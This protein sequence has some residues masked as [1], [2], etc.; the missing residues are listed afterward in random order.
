[1]EHR[2]APLL[3]HL[4]F[5]PESESAR[6]LARTIHRALNA[7]PQ[8]PGLRIPT[9]FCADDGEGRPPADQG[10]DE[11]R[12]SFVVPLADVEMNIDDDWCG[13]VA[14][15]WEA[16][17]EGPH[18]CF[19]IQLT[20]DAWPLDDRLRTINFVRGF[21]LSETEQRDF[22][23]RRIVIE[24]CRYLHG[25]PTAADDDRLPA[26][27]K[28]F[29]S[30]TK[31]DVG[32][33]PRVVEALS[34]YFNREQPVQVWFDSADIPG[35]SRF[36]R[37]I[38][39]GIQDSS[40][41]CV[42]TDRY[43]SREWCRK[44]VLLAKANAR[45]IVVINALSGSEV[46]S[47]P[48]LSNVPEL[49]WNGQPEQAVDLMLK[50]TLRHLHDTLLLKDWQQP[51]D[52]IFIYPPEHL[53]T[54][55]LPEGTRI[56]Y[57][58]PPLG[59]EEHDSLGKR[60]IS[61]ATPLE[62]VASERPLR[63]WRIAMSLSEST[64]IRRKGLDSV[65]FDAAALDLAR[66][67]LLK[68]TTL[69]YGG[70]LGSNGFT[71][72]LTNL[73]AAHNQQEDVDP[74]SRIENFIGWPLPFTKQLRSQYKGSARLRRIDRPAD[75]DETLA[76]EFTANPDFFKADL[77][78]KHRYAWARGMTSMRQAETDATQARIVM[79]GTFGPTEKI[80]GDGS[81][82]LSWY[83][84]RIP[85]VLEEAMLSLE[86][87][88]PLFLIGAFGGVAGLLIDLLEGRDRPE[89]YWDY[90]KQAPHAVAMR[91]L[92]QERGD[93]WWDYDEMRSL[94]LER[95]VEGLNPGL[96]ASEHRELFHTTDL[97]RMV[98][99]V[100]RGLDACE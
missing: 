97:M 1:M 37:A 19:P 63:G 83:S 62:R 21:G 4:V 42:R 9:R 81:K 65:H 45:P 23:I 64:D 35:G 13:F 34:N 18:R 55:E 14:D 92:Y 67:L 43:A 70:H 82:G 20:A 6:A 93:H 24:L 51:G 7:D 66:Y 84:S 41:L 32:T 58:D 48:Y 11:A 22:V 78:A 91:E 16:C 89:M 98:E 60:G 74:V 54:S 76:P 68:G 40:L 39:D 90:Q 72:Q 46:R 5:H 96:D 69:V 44:E 12:R 88:Q 8:V 50:E 38:S 77:S 79:G 30:H 29:I 36:A 87:G 75:I 57:P 31:L 27:T 61:L 86:S 56:L 25:D 85:G 3:V 15:L 10:L 52:R 94:L 17:Q 33:E 49:R 26:P 28:V 73:V 99:L 59:K 53:T 95:G 47:F 71:E 2:R 100:I 80:L